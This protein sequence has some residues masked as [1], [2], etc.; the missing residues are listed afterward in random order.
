MDM[1]RLRLPRPARRLPGFWGYDILIA[2]PCAPF[3]G[4]GRGRFAYPWQSQ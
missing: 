4:A 3:G 2:F 1:M